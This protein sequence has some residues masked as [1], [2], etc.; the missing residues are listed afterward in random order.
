MKVTVE[1][2]LFAFSQILEGSSLELFIV[3]HCLVKKQLN[4]SALFLKSFTFYSDEREEV[5]ND[6]FMLFNNDFNIDQ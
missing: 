4:D 2:G 6:F 3:E 5:C 1:I